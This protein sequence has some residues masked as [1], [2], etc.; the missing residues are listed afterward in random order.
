MNFYTA[1]LHLHHRNILKYCPNRADALGNKFT[2][3]EEMDEHIIATW[4]RYVGD[5]DMV[6]VLGDIALGP[7]DKTR[8]TLRRLRGRKLLVTGNHDRRKPNWYRN[9]GFEEV[10]TGYIP[11]KLPGGRFVYMSHYPYRPTL[12]EILRYALL[13]RKM[14]RFLNR[15]MPNEGIPLLHGHVH[16]HWRRKGNMLNVG[17][18][19]WGRPVSAE[20]IDKEFSWLK[21]TS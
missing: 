16:N 14:L 1:D 4:N 5:N 11:C 2:S 20:E 15:L 13:D 8:E 17:I 10:F 9:A 12:L 21:L 3:V 7:A 19:I 6:F 18:D